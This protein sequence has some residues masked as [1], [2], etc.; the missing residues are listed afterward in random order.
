MESGPPGS[1]VHGVIQ[2]RILEWV[3]IPFSRG[4]SQLRDRT[5]VSRI[6]GR[7][8]TVW[9]IR[10]PIC[11]YFFFQKI[12]LLKYSWFTILYWF[13]LYSKVTQLCIY[14]YSFS[15][16]FI[17]E[18]WIYFPVRYSGPCC[19]SILYITV[20]SANPKLPVLLSH[21]SLLPWQPQIYSLC[22]W[23]CF[24]CIDKFFCIIF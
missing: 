19:L 8:F 22:L 7:F 3:A 21:S 4:S 17:T 23:V 10:P 12:I 24:C 15:L 18:Y 20:W 6:A 11:Q 16:W 2:A 13:L 5:Q 14:P 1:S 9:A